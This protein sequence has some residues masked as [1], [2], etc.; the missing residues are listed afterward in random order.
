M[1]ATPIGN[2]ED[3]SSRAKAVLAE[4]DVIACEDTRHSRPL[5]AAFGIRGELLSFHE[6]NED[7]VTPRLLARLLAGEAVALI[8]DAG[9]PLISDPGFV[10]VRAAREQGVRV[11]PIP[12]PCAAICALSAAGLPSDRFLFVGF[13]PRTRA[14]RLAWCEDFVKEPGTIICYESGRRA[15]AT[16]ADMADALGADRRAVIARELTK[17]FETFLVDGLQALS[18]RL[19]SSPEQQLGELVILIEG[20]LRSEDERDRAE[21]LRVLAL[22]AAEL[23]LKQAA[24]LTAAITGGARNQLYK[25][26]LA[27]RDK[28]EA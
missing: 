12:G 9:T 22:L 15:A 10:L 26:A 14:Q 2:R 4:A 18:E 5:L 23:P 27:A 21:Q 6:H 17:R 13:P 16:L 3:I 28:T 19:A 11:E 24:A 20:D 25:A 8:S 7:Q 1:V